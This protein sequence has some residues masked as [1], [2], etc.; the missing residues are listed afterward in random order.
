MTQAELIARA[1]E[2]DEAAFVCL[3]R[4]VE[5]LAA[6]MAW[7]YG[8]ADE[9]DLEDTLQEM[10]LRLWQ[11]LHLCDAEGDDW[12]FAAWAGTVFHNVAV[13][14]RRRKA[15]RNHPVPFAD[16]IDP[17]PLPD[18]AA[19]ANEE[20]ALLLG[21][22][23]AIPSERNRLAVRLCHLGDLS[24]RELAHAMD[25]NPIT[26]KVRAFRGVAA[27]KRMAKALRPPDAR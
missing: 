1:R 5:G 22:I 18:A 2:S 7:R 6:A 11:K 3:F 16:T 26:A 15:R 21:L 23:G 10:R 9:G 8:N 24:I 27:M 20:R 14:V 19:I 17:K 4:S 13:D 12:R 25:C